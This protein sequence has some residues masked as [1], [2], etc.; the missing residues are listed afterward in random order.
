MSDEPNF[1]LSADRIRQLLEC[2]PAV[3]YKMPRW[4]DKAKNKLLFE[5][6]VGCNSIYAPKPKAKKPK[7]VKA[8]TKRVLLMTPRAISNRASQA[9][10]R[11]ANLEECRQR[12]REAMRRIRERQKQEAAR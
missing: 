2:K 1:G 12:T 3:G 7:V 8:K 6:K 9:K 10:W 11:L 4:E 5:D